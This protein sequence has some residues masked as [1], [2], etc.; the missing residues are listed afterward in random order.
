M[1]RLLPALSATLL[2]AGIAMPEPAWALRCGSRLVVQGDTAGEVK[3]RCGAPAEVTHNRVLRPP[4]IWLNGR[5][6]RIAREALEVPVE[7]W[8][9]N[10]GPNQF[11][12]RLRFE[13]GRVVQIDTLG[14]GYR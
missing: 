9:Y 3:A 5:P 6:V 12:R 11:M 7:V 4:V 13:D 14:Y 2:L 1:S 8:I 10:L